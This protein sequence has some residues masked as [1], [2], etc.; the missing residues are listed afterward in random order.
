MGDL[1]RKLILL[2]A[3]HVVFCTL[4][5]RSGLMGF[6]FFTPYSKTVL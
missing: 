2:I 4:H 5:D 1:I 3:M 6:H